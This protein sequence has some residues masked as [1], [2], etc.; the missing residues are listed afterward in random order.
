MQLMLKSTSLAPSSAIGSGGLWFFLFFLFGFVLGYG[1]ITV[2][3][4]QAASSDNE[5]GGGN[6]PQIVVTGEILAPAS[7]EVFDTGLGTATSGVDYGFTSPQVI[8]FPAGNYSSDVFDLST[9]SISNENVVELDETIEFALGDA[10]GDIIPGTNSTTVYSILNDDTGDVTISA[11]DGSA[12]EVGTDTGAFQVDLGAVNGTGGDIT[13][14]LNIANASTADEITDFNALPTSIN[15]TAGN[16][17][18]TILLT[19]VDDSEIE[20][21]EFVRLEITGT[22][23]ETL[24]PLGSPTSADVTIDSEDV[25]TVSI[26]NDTNGAENNG[27]GP[28][29]DGVLIVT[30]TSVSPVDTEITYSV[31]GTATEGDD[32]ST[33]SGTLTIPQGDTSAEIGINVLE[34]VIV[35]GD[36]T[37]IITLTGISSGLAQLDVPANIEATNTIIDDDNPTATLTATDDTAT[38]TGTTTGEFTVNLDATNIS[39]SP[40]TINYSV[41]GTATSGDD[42]IALTGSVQIA[43]NSSSAT[44]LL[45]P[46]D[47]TEV[48]VDETVILNLEAGTGYSVGNPDEATVTIVSEDIPTATI[49]A[50]D[51]TSTESG[52]TTGE[53]T[54][55]LDVANISGSPL[56]IDYTVS[57][58]ATSGDDFIAL[59]GTVE[60]ANNSSS[61]MILL[62]PVNDTEIEIDETVVLTLNAG[63]GYTVG[64]PNNATVT[65]ISEDS[66]IATITATDDTAT[67]LGTTE[68]IFTV[69]IGSVNN[70]G[71][72]LTVNY[73]VS[74]DAIPDD[75]YVT[76][77]GSVNIIDGQQ[78]A[79]IVV[80]PLD[81]ALTEL[82]ET[83]IV[84]LEAG[85]GY[86]IGAPNT[87][88][89]TIES[90][91]DVPP[92][93]YTVTIDQ[94]PINLTNDENVSFSLA[95]A[96]TF[97][98]T[99][100]YI[101]T[102]DGDG[103]VAEVT[104]NG[105]V[106][107]ANRNVSGI[108]L[109][110]LPDGVITLSVIIS[111]ALGTEG[112]ATTDT[113]IKNTVVPTG[114]SVS[115]NQNPITSNNEDN[116]SFTFS[117][118]VFGTTYNYVFSSSGGGSNV[119]GT[120]GITSQSQ[121][122]TGVNLSGLGDGTITL[123]VTLTNDNGAGPVAVDA[124]TKFVAVPSGYSV[125]IN[126]DP[127]NSGND[128]NIGFTFSGAEVGADYEYS[129]SSDGGGAP[130]TGLG[131]IS[132]SN[133]QITGID[134][135]N[136]G[137]GTI[138]LSV[139]LS[140]VNGDGATAIDNV[141]KETCYAGTTA[142]SLDG[143]V[144][145]AFCDAFN[146]DLD[147]YISS[148]APAG[149]DL[150]WSNNSD[151][152]VS[153]DY[154]GGSVVSAPGTYYG[155]FYD[156]LNDCFSPAVSVTLT[157]ST[158]PNAGTANNVATCSNSNDGI[159][160]VDLDTTLTG[161]D[162]G[163]WTLLTSPAGNSISIDGT[164]SVDFNGQPEG[165]YL[166][167]YT[168]TGAVAPC[169]NQFVDVTVTVNDCA[170]PCNAG[171]TAPQFNGDDTTIEFCDVV[172][173]DLSS[174]VSGTAPTGTVLTWSTSDIPTDTGAHLNSST[175]VEP[176]TYYGFYYDD[177]NDC[178]SPVLDLTLVRN[179]TPVIETTMGDSNCGPSILTLT[180]TATVADESVITYNW[181]D[182]ATGGNLVGTS[183]T[184]TTNTLSETT[185]FYVSA[186]AN[187]CETER[188]EVVAEIN[189]SPNV[190]TPT[191]TI[192]CNVVGNGGPNSVDLDTTLSSAD[193]G[194]W[195]IF[196]DPSEGALVVDAENNVDFAGLPAGNY[197][198]EYTTTGAVA[199]C[200]NATVQVTI[201]VSDCITDTDGDGLTDGEEADLG[202]DPNNPD[203]D[204]D[205]LTD[206]EEV[207]VIDNPDTVAVPENATDPL[208]ACDPFL[209]PDC[210][211]ADIDLAITKEVNRTE[212]LLNQNVTFSITVENTTL[213]RVLD[214]VVSDV[215]GNGFE[216]QSHSASTGTYDPNT[217]EWLI[218]E[219]GA[220]EIV[221]L[222]ITVQVTLVETL[223][224]TASLVSSFPNDLE[225]NNNT[226][227]A[228][229]QVNRSQCEDIG[230]IC[231]I[232]SP[233]N[234]GINDRLT[235]VG[236]EQFPNNTFEVF[237]RY[238]NS[239]FQMNGYDSSWDGTGKN[240]DLPKGTYF[241][242]L[243][244]NGDGSDV[245]KGWIQIVRDN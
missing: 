47:D 78:T 29:T 234:D 18:A 142:P 136:L 84:A 82:D 150:R 25:V 148:T 233:N 178:A 80:D 59:T 61:A 225:P 107:T 98:T 237:D 7:I 179:F 141:T 26:A 193:A 89:V 60:I 10:T 169:A 202:T 90:E 190:G 33:L 124:S 79:V 161:A 111:N 199:P 186:S 35:E 146:Q 130:I 230:T 51:N 195:A 50:T 106:L 153:A 115:I 144:P 213:D 119:T 217:G 58:T 95:N 23:N 45:T 101:F 212:V 91:D 92:S 6:F 149:A 135:S 184:F 104:G 121:Q 13:V 167:R 34:D 145:T 188:V 170:G 66:P 245:V 116:I 154:L 71:A 162:A 133:Q 99:F 49:T 151:I 241:Y 168:T 15:I 244:L 22:S 67:E 126:Q 42:F 132:T 74:G 236:H 215:L 232:F 181:Y 221:T 152:S 185:S 27:G 205:G 226:D 11:T 96:P 109:S 14:D 48:E 182:A 231:T 228:S 191:N 176:G 40:L 211:P 137:N 65:I 174:Y 158:T 122:I 242:I 73:S 103:N 5:A 118:A 57:G 239:V 97:L 172:N 102:S 175:V 2:E 147:F 12:S 140:N 219:L 196:T 222:D 1:Q 138:T 120:G 54:V 240:G 52:T 21:Q 41:S 173:T 46:I 81:D 134:L 55:T 192:A 8:D 198:F 203:T 76:L 177:V 139:V 112:P 100:D 108:D 216:Y 227:S 171:N 77:S 87:A 24:F 94:D 88:T 207:L 210:N 19:P 16:Q 93:G 156:S 165:N 220:E 128:T 200:T 117:N 197:V 31:S 123:S 208:D 105:F 235:L 63:I 44:I 157:Q 209:T 39:G 189:D 69:D 238:G 206:G 68:G 113:A 72:T 43:N 159:T 187:G 53:Y 223:Q 20:E 4:T 214:V 131:T 3:F 38:E 160:I 32:Y 163:T 75:D 110:S 129:F 37:V 36:E 155:F 229:V 114:Y 143:G 9:L 70:T 125:S 183:A 164:N 127:I 243:D 194:T 85:S 64:S 28:P 83:V 218:D 86:T 17:T 166:F 201:S 224:N 56:A 30:Q 180:A 204:G 62:T